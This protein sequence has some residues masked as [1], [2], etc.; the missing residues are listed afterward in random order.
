MSR[1]LP[2]IPNAGLPAASASVPDRV[3]PEIE[4]IRALGR[5]RPEPVASVAERADKHI[6]LWREGMAKIVLEIA[7]RDDPELDAAFA[8]IQRTQAWKILQRATLESP[9]VMAALRPFWNP[10]EKVEIRD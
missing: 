2:T 5:P 10:D 6:Q 9:K 7:V 1:N 4:A 3:A 8:R